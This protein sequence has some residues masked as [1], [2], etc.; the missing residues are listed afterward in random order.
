MAPIDSVPVAML[1][2]VSVPNIVALTG[3]VPISI[4]VES[5]GTVSIGTVSIGTVSNVL[6]SDV[7]VSIPGGICNSSSTQNGA[8]APELA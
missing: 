7:L 5:I 4:I 1:S 8:V 6:V 2:T 3:S